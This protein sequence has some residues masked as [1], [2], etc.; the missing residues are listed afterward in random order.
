MDGALADK[1][2]A[3][4]SHYC[5][6]ATSVRDVVDTGLRSLLQHRLTGQ[7]TAELNYLE[8]LLQEV[9]YEDTPDQRS[10]FFEDSSHRLMTGFIYRSSTRGDHACPSYS[11]VWKN[12]ARPE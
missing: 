2:P 4:H 10:S 6:R 7:A 8:D 12:F 1:V 11:F 5:G 9:S 3:L